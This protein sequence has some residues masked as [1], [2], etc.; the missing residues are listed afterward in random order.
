MKDLYNKVLAAIISPIFFSLVMGWMMHTPMEEREYECC[1]LGFLEGF[2]MLLMPSLP[3][4]IVFGLLAAY[5]VDRIMEALNIK[6]FSYLVQLILYAMSGLLPALFLGLIS[7]GIQWT[8]IYALYS[9]PAALI[10]YHI[11][12]GLHYFE[13]FRNKRYSA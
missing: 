10:Y 4:Y 9:V 1:Y 8:L 7:E 3:I 12:L 2:L 5:V 6:R 11:F 13:K